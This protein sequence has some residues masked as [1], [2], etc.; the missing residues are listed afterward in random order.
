[1]DVTFLENRYLDV[2]ISEMQGFFE[3]NGFAESEGLFKNDKKALKIEYDED[4]QIYNLLAADVSEG[5]VGEFAVISSYLFDDSQTKNDAVSVGID[6]VDSA[7]K[8]L[9]VKNSGRRTSG[10]AELPT[11]NSNTVNVGTLTAKLL[12][13]YPELKETYKYE[14][15]KKGKFLYLDFYTTYFV[16]RVRDTLDGGNKKATKKLI[17]MLCEIFTEGDRASVNLVIALLAAAIGTNGDR[18][19]A[20][21]DKMEDCPHLVSSVN[22]EISVLVKNKKL[23]KALK[24]EN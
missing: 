8:A 1:L 7:R 10:G 11:A 22:N 2:I 12:A 15:E 9:G 3:Q 13:N 14:V 6:F 19:K 24:F 20:A 4:K 18:F 21:T 5:T 23:Q 17:D 16:P